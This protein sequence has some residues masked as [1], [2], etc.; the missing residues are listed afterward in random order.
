[1]AEEGVTEAELEAAKKYI[2]G[3]YAINNLNSSGAIAG[4]LGRIADRRPRHRLYPAPQGLIEAVTLDRS[5]R[6]RSGCCSPSRQ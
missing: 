3:S 2:V 4:T 1:M 6:R 5:R